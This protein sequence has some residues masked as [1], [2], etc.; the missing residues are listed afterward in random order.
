MK[1]ELKEAKDITTKE[2]KYPYI[3]KFINPTDAEDYVCV[4]F[5]DKN[6]GTTLACGSDGRHIVG[7]YSEM[8]DEKSF[9]ILP[10][11]SQIVLQN[12]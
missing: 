6:S 12:D 9:E 5:I 10:S 8:W 1:S 4:L 11:T 2:R 7:S 3:G